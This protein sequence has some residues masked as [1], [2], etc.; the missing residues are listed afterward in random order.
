MTATRKRRDRPRYLD[1]RI[2]H[3]GELV[4]VYLLEKIHADRAIAS[5]V[6]TWAALQPAD[7]TAYEQYVHF[8]AMRGVLPWG[9]ERWLQETGKGANYQFDKWARKSRKERNDRDE[10][11]GSAA[12]DRSQSQKSAWLVGHVKEQCGSVQVGTLPKGKGEGEWVVVDGAWKWKGLGDDTLLSVRPQTSSIIGEG[13]TSPLASR[14]CR[15]CKL[16]L[17]ALRFSKKRGI[18]RET[19]KSCDNKQRVERRRAAKK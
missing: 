9:V 14:T 10:L 8:A 11:T 7:A 4:N 5:P 15:K 1:T 13:N 2:V 12:P 6:F 16:H 3:A 19:C 17:P 18:I